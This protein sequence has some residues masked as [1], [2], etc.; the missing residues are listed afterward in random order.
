M[1]EQIES[2]YKIK[3]WELYELLKGRRALTTKW[4]DKRKE[5][6]PRVQNARWKARLVV[7]GYNQKEGIDFDAVSYTHLTLPTKRIV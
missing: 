1:Q 2:L 7:Q 3:T 5:G 6:I 4:I